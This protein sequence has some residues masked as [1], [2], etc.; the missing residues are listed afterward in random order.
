[1]AKRIRRGTGLVLGT[2]LMGMLFAGC[3]KGEAGDG[4][5]ELEVS[6]IESGEAATQSQT[7]IVGNAIV[8]DGTLPMATTEDAAEGSE[9]EDTSDDFHEDEFAEDGWIDEDPEPWDGEEFADSEE[10]ARAHGLNEWGEEPAEA[11]SYKSVPQKEEKPHV[12][13]DAKVEEGNAEGVDYLVLVN[14]SNPLDEDWEKTVPLV[15][16]PEM[17]GRDT[18]LEQG[19]YAAYKKLKAGLAEQGIHIA[20][21]SAYRSV[22]EQQQLMDDYLVQFGEEYV[23]QYVAKPGQSEH[24]TGLAIDINIIDVDYAHGPEEYGTVANWNRVH[25][26]L[27]DYGFILRYQEG[28]EA[29]T[30]YSYEQWHIRYVGSAEVAH[31]IMNED[32]TLEEYLDR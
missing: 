4:A 9:A 23:R 7:L 14:K 1:M 21:G 13:F 18:Y 2:L 25:E 32:L 6:Q 28:K 20:I 31:K 19:C 3:G 16:I 29:I 26:C 12:D 11:V 30:G 17:S 8:Q 24:H 5:K 27:G 15:K 10:E 22:E